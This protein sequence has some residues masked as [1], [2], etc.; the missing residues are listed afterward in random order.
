M[1]NPRC[2]LFVQP[3]V[4]CEASRRAYPSVGSSLTSSPPTVIEPA[5]AAIAS[6]IVDLPVPFSPTKKVTGDR[7]SISSNVRTTGRSNGYPSSSAPLR[8]IHRDWR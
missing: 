3:S 8:F 4:R 6:R 5:P 1:K 7:N 2:V